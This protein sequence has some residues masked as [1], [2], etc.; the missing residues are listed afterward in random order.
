MHAVSCI[1]GPC[2]LYT[3][4]LDMS[5]EVTLR[6]PVE[7]DLPVFYEQQLD[8]VATE[9]AAFPPGAREPFM[10]HW[11]KIMADGTVRLRTILSDGRVAGNVVSFEQSGEREVGYWLG[12]D[13]WDKGIATAA[14]LQFL[15]QETTRP[16]YAHVARHNVASRRVLEKCGFRL[17]REDNGLSLEPGIVLEEYVLVLEG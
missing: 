5:D 10:A 14:L 11:K 15:E 6:E 7:A 9:M 2:V 4:V 16:L 13:Y 8:P 12:R 1:F 17:L 3:E